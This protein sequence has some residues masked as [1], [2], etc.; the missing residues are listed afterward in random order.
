VKEWE[1]LCPAHPAHL[2]A[3]A[4]WLSFTSVHTPFLLTPR[5]QP[6]TQMLKRNTVISRG[7]SRFKGVSFV[8]RPDGNH[9]WEARLGLKDEAEVGAAAGVAHV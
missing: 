5:L 7:T 6:Q 4:L 1:R 2:R 3:P 9:K 8:A